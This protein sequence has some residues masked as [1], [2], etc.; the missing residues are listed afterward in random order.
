MERATREGA[1]ESAVESEGR[2]E[3]E[4]QRARLG[5]DAVVLPLHFSKATPCDRTG[6]LGSCM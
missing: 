6:R 1:L 3:R 2:R 4:R 5:A